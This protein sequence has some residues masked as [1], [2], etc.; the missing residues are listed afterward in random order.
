M[1]YQANEVIRDHDN[2]ISV[3]VRGV[4]N[5]KRAGKKK[6][7]QEVRASIMGGWRAGRIQANLL[8][9]LHLCLMMHSI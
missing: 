8:S 5:G 3:N 1:R 2:S 7:T 6:E 4:A 9:V